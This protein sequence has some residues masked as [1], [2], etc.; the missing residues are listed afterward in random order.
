MASPTYYDEESKLSYNG[1][2]LP[3]KNLGMDVLNLI[4]MQGGYHLE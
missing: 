2:C 3:E 4:H 1:G